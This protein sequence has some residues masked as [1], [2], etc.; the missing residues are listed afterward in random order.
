MM[1]E[2]LESRRLM[3]VS[4]NST[5]G[6]VTVVGGDDGGP[7]GPITAEVA[8]GRFVV[9]DFGDN[10]VRSYPAA[11]VKRIVVRT[12]TNNSEVN[13]AASVTV[14]SEI[15][16]SPG[17]F[18]ASGGSGPDTIYLSGGKEASGGAGNDRFYLSGE[19]VVALGG[20]GN[21]TFV[22]AGDGPRD[23]RAHGEGGYDTIDY[24]ANRTGLLFQSWGAVGRYDSDS[25]IPPQMNN[26]GFDGNSGFE[27]V[28]GTQG[29]DFIYGNASANYLD[30]Q[31]GND[32]IRGGGGNDVLVG[33]GGAD[34]LYGD[35]GDDQFFSRDGV[36]DFLSGGAGY[37]RRRADAIDVLNSVEG[38]V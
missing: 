17:A 10:T 11:A 1:F 27:S 24:S 25:G 32:Y 33:G 15:R 6:V 30:G 7:G 9:R 35:S 38:T 22:F 16:L 4:F 18:R 31:G 3:S 12:G 2:A 29:N 26:D 23:R 19:D 13:L 20:T 36:K 14:P 37:D 28:I 5:S 34:A 8:A 21:D